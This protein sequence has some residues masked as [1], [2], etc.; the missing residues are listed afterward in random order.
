MSKY[1]KVL[2]TSSLFPSNQFSQLN[3]KSTK[4]NQKKFHS[5]SID[6]G[7]P[8]V[9]K[10]IEPK[11]E[12]NKYSIKP[13]VHETNNSI[14]INISFNY[15]KNVLRS[16][17]Q[18]SSS[19]HKSPNKKA[20]SYSM[21]QS[22]QKRNRSDIYDA[23]I[24]HN[25]LNI[26]LTNIASPKINNSYIVNRPPIRVEVKH[27]EETTD[28]Q[29]LL[30]QSIITELR[31]EQ[32]ELQAKNQFLEKQLEMLNT[33]NHMPVQEVKETKPIVQNNK[34]NQLLIDKIQSNEG[35][36]TTLQEQIISNESNEKINLLFEDV[37][38]V[39]F[40]N[41][42]ISKKSANN[43]FSYVFSQYTNNIEKDN[44]DNAKDELISSLVNIISISL[45][46]NNNEK[47]K[48]EL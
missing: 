39:N 44:D 5:S 17:E 11:I 10:P 40:E 15:P 45:H 27:P 13:N 31:E 42:N 24:I 1:Q 6:S 25:N 47:D 3:G 34:S 22:S 18:V 21:N 36:L 37:L 28:K 12:N 20:T 38:I 32:K 19:L 35:K 29:L 41:N 4:Y 33:S 8:R 14:D 43:L 23:N 9:K 26:S 7:L 48:K 30:L 46:C 2:F 16:F